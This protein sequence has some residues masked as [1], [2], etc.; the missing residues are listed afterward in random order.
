MEIRVLRYFLAVVREENITRAADMLHITQ[1]TL[2]RQLAEL[3]EE[4]GAPLF[5]RGKRRI[6][7]TDAG[8]LLRRRAEEIVELA[9]KTEQEFSA[10]QQELSGLISLGSAV[11]S[12]AR[13]WAELLGNFRLR[14]PRVRFDLLF[15]NADQIKERVDRGL[16]DVAL[17]LEPVEFEKYEFLRLG[18]KEVWGLLARRDDPLAAKGYVT[19]E[20]L[21]GR[22]LMI[23]KRRMVQHEA[24]GWFGDGFDKLD[25]FLT[26]NLLAN[27]VQM[28]EAGLGCAIT[29]QGAVSAHGPGETCFLPFVPELTNT[30]VLAWKKFQ[31]FSPAVT[32]FLEEIKMLYRHNDT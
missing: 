5:V 3:E 10:P 6:T 16:I 27:A 31:S 7:L 18:E 28:V 4:L 23:S 24:A 21:R 25:I 15:G 26:Y 9:D 17:L 14:H 22:P 20:D 29:I 8:M 32:A 2:S 19:P 12:S 13:I 1:P 30:S 11:T